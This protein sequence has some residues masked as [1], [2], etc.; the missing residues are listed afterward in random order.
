MSTDS[1]P[2]PLIS[3]RC[4]LRPNRGH[5][6]IRRRGLAE[7]RLNRGGRLRN[8][9]GMGTKRNID[10][11]LG[12]YMKRKFLRA[13][14]MAM[15]TVHA[16]IIAAM[17]AF[18][19][20]V[21]AKSGP[22]LGADFAGFYS[23]G[24][25]L[26]RYPPARLYDLN[27]QDEVFHD[28]FPSEGR[29]ERLTFLHA[30]WFALG[31][32]LLA[33]LPYDVAF[34][35]WLAV[36][37]G[38][39]V[40]A[41]VLTVRAAP[42]I[43]KQDRALAVLL[44]ISFQPLIMETLIGGQA[45][46]FGLFVFAMG[47]VLL[48]LRMHFAAGV[49]LAFLSY[50]PTL[51]LLVLPFLAVSGRFR[52]LAGFAAGAAGLS[53]VTLAVF[54]PDCFLSYGTTLIR[55]E[56]LVLSNAWQFK[57]I[58]YVDLKS[59]LELLTG[60]NSGAAKSV[61]IAAGLLSVAISRSWWKTAGKGDLSLVPA[62]AAVM[63]WTLVLNLYAPI[64]DTAILLPGIVVFAGLV[65]GLDSSDFIPKRRFE[66]LMAFVYITPLFSQMCAASLGFQPM[67]CVLIALA[68]AQTRIAWKIARG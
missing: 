29:S 16:A 60:M 64:Y 44:C 66:I 28:V 46:A 63:T 32:P 50:K 68:L 15:I 58:K 30:P 49:V 37:I 57:A 17:F 14:S 54:G 62:S 25:L 12:R 11:L 8:V 21:P 33:R 20:R 38:L 43:A 45:S 7:R 35:V 3:G 56:Q 34:A 59:F 67:T 9:Q 53:V 19:P 18:S 4:V 51:L 31:L 27:L 61:S 10:W 1:F 5:R 24:K 65:R 39:S 47:L 55:Y 41:I 48:D 22:M 26:D 40:S 42:G 36:S 6:P 52:T 2:S 23:A 13:A